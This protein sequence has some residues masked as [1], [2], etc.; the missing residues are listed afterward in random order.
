[1]TK[2][3]TMDEM[4]VNR[5]NARGVFFQAEGGIR[6]HCVPGVQTCALPISPD[7]VLDFAQSPEAVMAPHVR[8][9]RVLQFGTFEVDL[10]AGDLR[11]SGARIRLQEQPFQILT[12]LL[13]KPGE[14]IT[15]EELQQKLWP[16]DTFVDFD[17]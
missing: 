3:D 11:K 13:E 14:V 1:M 2:E 4:R 7:W 15:R 9:S 16:A 8:A 5:L 12:M 17:D 10:R 6:D